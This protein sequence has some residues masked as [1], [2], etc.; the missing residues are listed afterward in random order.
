MWEAI[1]DIVMGSCYWGYCVGKLL[2]ILFEKLLVILCWEAIG[3]IVLLC[4]E[5]AGKLWGPSVFNNLSNQNISCLLLVN[6]CIYNNLITDICLHQNI[7][8]I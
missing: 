5:L 1:G 8:Y 2:G 4:W 3:N 7:L 6:V